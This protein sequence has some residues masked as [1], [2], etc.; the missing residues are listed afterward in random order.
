V[1]LDQPEQE[2]RVKQ[3]QLVQLAR[4]VLLDQP[5]RDQRVKQAQLVQLV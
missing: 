1:L 4:Q 5:E 3:A 2:Q